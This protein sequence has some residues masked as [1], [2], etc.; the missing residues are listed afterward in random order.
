VRYRTAWVGSPGMFEPGGT[1]PEATTSTRP[2]GMNWLPIA[3][4]LAIVLGIG[5]SLLSRPAPRF[6]A[7]TGPIA[8]LLERA[9]ANDL[10]YPG[11]ERGAA[12]SAEP[13]RGDSV[14]NRAVE[15]AVEEMR[16]RYERGGRSIPDLFA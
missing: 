14:E 7:P 2:R 1:E 12:L 4:G 11:G 15:A 10:V 8:G 16:T 9:S 3:A 13:Y 6:A 5:A